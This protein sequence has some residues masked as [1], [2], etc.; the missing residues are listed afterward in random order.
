[1]TGLHTNSPEYARMVIEKGFQFVTVMTDSTI[2]GTYANDLV[3]ATR[4][5]GDTQM[6]NANFCLLDLRFSGI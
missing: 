3:N 6:Y 2:L 1:M 4:N 5:G